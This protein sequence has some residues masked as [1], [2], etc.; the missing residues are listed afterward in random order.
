VLSPTPLKPN[1]ALKIQLPIGDS[2]IASK[3]KGESTISCKGKI[4]WAQLEPSSKGAARYRGGVVFTAVDATA[5][6]A[7]IAR[8]AP[9]RR[10]V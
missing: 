8:H 7:F 6:A 2:T 9:R 5:I 1:R 4:V 3:G 10:K